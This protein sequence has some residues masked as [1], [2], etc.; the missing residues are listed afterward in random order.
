MEVIGN[1]R[2]AMHLPRRGAASGWLWPVA[3]CP[4]DSTAAGASRA[5][6]TMNARAPSV[7]LLIFL[8]LAPTYAYF[9]QSTQHNEAARFDQARAI[10]EER[11]FF[12]NSFAWNT[13]DVV[14]IKVDGVERV[15]PAK[16]PGSSFLAVAPMFL[17]KSIGQLAGIPDW[18]LWHIVVY[19]CIVLLVAVPSALAAAAFYDISVRV[20]QARTASL[21]SIVAVWLGSILFPFSTLY[22]GHAQ[23]AALLVASFWIIFRFRHDGEKAFAR[24]RLMLALAG[25]SAGFAV[26]NEYPAIF[27]AVPLGGYFL[28]A[29]WSHQG[30]QRQKLRLADAFAA[31]ALAMVAVLLAYNV[32]AFDKLFFAPYQALD[33]ESA[34]PGGALGFAGIHWP[35]WKNFTDVLAQTLLLPQRGLL[36]LNPVL[37]TAIPGF[38]LWFRSRIFRL[39]LVLVA[40]LA[41]IFVVEN[42][43]YGNSIVYWGGGASTGPRQV[44]LMLPFLALPIAFFARTWRWVF[45]VP[46]VA[47]VFFMLCATSTQ[48][49]I[50]YDEQNPLREFFIPNFMAGK[51]GLDDGALF[52]PDNHRLLGAYNAF[53]LGGLAR[54][55]GVWQ[56]LPLLVWWALIA[57]RARRALAAPKPDAA[58]AG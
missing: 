37:I 43:C 39:E 57:A 9:Y 14:V 18:L 35:G 46:L 51:F 48:P 1:A 33:S 49:R 2:A 15:F 30:L 23:T 22:F 56:M 44:I 13:A 6:I 36:Y 40:A 10:L 20:T 38:V 31:G 32:A 24:P 5:E 26:I 47:S 45:L 42:A 7:P 3:N 4:T 16:A 11:Q 58:S 55:P 50:G 25:I 52:D 41:V 53:N 28:A 29:L 27:A 34:F 19:V 8:L 12:I 54:I 17:T 21:L